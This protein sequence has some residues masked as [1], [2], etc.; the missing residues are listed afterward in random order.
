MHSLINNA[1]KKCFQC[2]WLSF[3]FKVECQEPID[4][5]KRGYKLRVKLIV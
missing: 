4:S 3:P 5:N 2:E 1:D